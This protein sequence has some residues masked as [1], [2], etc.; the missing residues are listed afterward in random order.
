MEDEIQWKLRGLFRCVLF[1]FIIS[2]IIIIFKLTEYHVLT[3]HTNLKKKT[4][5]QTDRLTYRQTDRQTDWQTDLQTKRQTYR[6]TNRLT[7]RQTILIRELLYLDSLVNPVITSRS[8]LPH[9]HWPRRV[10]GRANQRRECWLCQLQSTP[11]AS[12]QTTQKTRDLLCPELCIH[13]FRPKRDL[14]WRHFWG[15]QILERLK[16]IKRHRSMSDA[17][18]H[19]Q[20]L[21]RCTQVWG[22]MWTSPTGGQRFVQIKQETLQMIRKHL[23]EVRI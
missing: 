15:N 13:A 5:L 17:H 9:D 1:L 22:I 2:T 21:M 10:A 4:Y 3:L 11:I 7:D 14:G 8:S 18:A 23:T 6:Q 16:R 20:A 12:Q 19:M